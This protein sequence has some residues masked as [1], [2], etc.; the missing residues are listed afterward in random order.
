MDS[1]TFIAFDN[2][3][4][5][6]YDTLTV[7][8]IVSDTAS[9]V[10][11][12]PIWQDSVIT[13][14][15]CVGNA[16]NL[17]LTNYCSD[18]DSD[19]LT[20]SL[21]A[22]TPATDTIS[23]SIYTFT[24]T[25]ADTGVFY[26]KII[27]K[28]PSG[29]ADTVTLHIT[30]TAAAI[31]DNTVPTLRFLSPSKDTIISTD[32]A[33]VQVI[34]KDASGIA[35]L[36]CIVDTA[37]FTTTK[38]TTAD[39][40]WSATV[41]GLKAGQY[42]T[43]KFIATDSSSAANKDSVSIKIKYDND[44]TKPTVSLV[45]PSKDTV[46]TN[47]GSYMITLK[48][49]DASGIASVIGVINSVYDTG[50]KE[51]DSTY[52]ITVS[53]LTQGVFDT[54]KIT[55]TDNSLKANKAKTNIKIKYDS[56]LADAIG[57][58]INK[59]SGPKDTVNSA[60]FTIVDSITDPSGIDSV[61]AVLNSST[62]KMVLAGISNKYTYTGTLSEGANTIVVTAKDKS[63]VGNTS[64]QT[65]LVYYR[66]A[67]TITTEPVAQIAC[68]GTSVTFSIAATGTRPFIY[69]WYKG[70]DSVGKDSVYT[71]SS[72]A[73]TDT[74]YYKVV[75]TN[76][77]GAGT[78]ASVKLTVNTVSTKP[79]ATVSSSSICS[80]TSDTLKVSSGILGTGANW[81]WYT[82]M[83][84]TAFDSGVLVI[85]A[86]SSSTTYY[87]RGE[88]TCGN[89][90]WD[91]V[92]VTIKT[93]ATV[94][95]SITATSTSVTLGSS[96][97]L[98]V[99]GGSLGTDAKWKWYTGSCG[100]TLID[101]GNAITAKPTST[102]T[103]YVRAL[104]GCANTECVNTTIVVDTPPTITTQPTAQTRWVEDSV[105]FSVS[106]KG[107]GTLSYQWYHGSSALSGKTIAV[108]KIDSITGQSDSG[109][110]KC[111]VKSSYGSDTSDS[112]KLTV[113]A[114]AAVAA[115]GAHSLILK[116]D[117]TLWACGY[118]SSGQLGIG[119]TIDTSIPV[120]I[121]TGVKSIAAG[122]YQ[123]FVLKTD[124]SLWAC[125]KSG[126]NGTSSEK[127]ML[128][129]IAT[130]VT[131]IS[132]GYLHSMIIKKGDSLWGCGYNAY[133][134][135]GAGSSIS[136]SESDTLIKIEDSI[137]NVSAGDYRH[138]LMIKTDSTIWGCGENEGGELGLC[139]EEEYDPAEQLSTITGF[140]K[141]AAGGTNSLFLKNDGTIWGI[142][143]KYQLSTIS[144]DT[145]VQLST[146]IGFTNI[147]SG[148]GF[149]LFLKSNSLYACGD[150]SYGQLGNGTT[151]SITTVTQIMS[152]ISSVS[153]GYYHTLIIKTDGSLWAC[154]KNSN[155]QL[156][157]GSK[158]STGVLSPVRIR[159]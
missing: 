78:S 120:K 111:I 13:L 71:I 34:C 67:P 25:K 106:A 59:I 10:N 101:S 55:V 92:G 133:G 19:A 7:H 144:V 150:N 42:S 32:S 47:A 132:A 30:I 129:E 6:L 140:I 96:T 81:Q 83:N 142:N 99:S 100:G 156:G 39:S 45:M 145:L 131:A 105:T 27:A 93:T 124:G 157:N 8:I 23:A 72:A 138:T 58:V 70:V 52:S 94:P 136:S 44:T 49:T 85:I 107:T 91:S 66:I 36:K 35:S 5:V 9:K 12:P 75:V 153:A 126:T 14:S 53:N 37:S 115:G 31:T 134:Q 135:L 117:G 116:T 104:G 127:D 95:T 41:K 155:G 146:M 90:R 29:L 11:H 61:Y 128:Y 33:K 89:S 46:S 16:L 130:G 86:P 63:T 103:Y 84:G 43:I 118:N 154:G 102:T 148:Y 56:T 24:P 114:V 64:T 76:G 112:V 109:Y 123:S 147:F 121:T 2:G 62:T 97:T 151:T 125:G 108:C 57:P 139:C 80:G 26:P 4:P 60:S 159:F 87:V 21:I 137:M 40:V 77:S 65:I 141:C 82:D 110:Y 28:A 88:G 15:G 18:P 51:T 69:K 17:T 74:G 122:Y 152:D 54:V 149:S 22:G 158:S 98:S 3:E 1:V 73:V 50:T 143:Y 113:S 68:A 48:C 119:S 79:T 20:F 38:S